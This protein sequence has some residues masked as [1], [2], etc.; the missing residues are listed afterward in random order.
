MA[1]RIQ[2]RHAS[3]LAIVG[4]DST[5]SKLRSAILLNLRDWPSV[6]MWAY[7]AYSLR[8]H[9]YN[10]EKE[11]TN[12]F[13]S[14]RVIPEKMILR[15]WRAFRS[16]VVLTLYKILPRWRSLLYR[17]ST[18]IALFSP[19]LL[20]AFGD[21]AST[22]HRPIVFR[23]IRFDVGYHRDR[24]IRCYIFKRTL[25]YIAS[26]PLIIFILIIL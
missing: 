23:I 8:L 13:A 6:C 19:N 26:N 21:F 18:R 14:K 9:S 1:K 12:V 15:N 11:F 7:C 16:I 5:Q 2:I 20:N 10:R 3:D 25:S 24:L 4:N 17:A 22:L